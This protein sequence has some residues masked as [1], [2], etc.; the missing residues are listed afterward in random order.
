M[1]TVCSET[2][3]GRLRHVGVV[4]VDT[5]RVEAAASVPDEHDLIESQLDIML[6]PDD[7]EVREQARRDGIADDW[8]EAASRSPVYAMCKR[9]RIALPLHPE[10]R[11][12]P[13]VWYVPPLSPV[14][15]L[16]ESLVRD[17]GDPDDVFEAIEELRIPVE[18]LASFLSAGDPEPVRRSLR[19]LRRDAPLHARQATSRG[20]V[21]PEIAR[22][23]GMEP[24]QMEA[25]FRMV[26]IGDYD[27]RYVIPKRHG[28]ASPAAFAEQGSCGIDFV[29]GAALPPGMADPRAGDTAPPTPTSTSATTSCATGAATGCAAER[30][31]PAEA[32]LAAAPVPDRRR[33]RG[34]RG[35]RPEQWRRRAAASARAWRASS[36]GTATARWRSFSAA[37]VEDLRLRQ[38]AQ[39]PPHLPPARRQPPAR[40][41]PAALKQAY[42]EAGLERDAETSCPTSCR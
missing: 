42:A 13:M 14:E 38:A 40:A 7:P 2:C 17:G 22:E 20:E 11:T 4:L 12:L 27:E 34:G 39:P 33:A 21:D 36:T 41:G 35:A 1:P 5:D 29:N 9:W 6:D 15:S 32:G 37:Y 3:V 28:E 26:A 19:R 16:G 8:L 24:V 18:Y 10:Y 30:R 25:M 23:V 31:P